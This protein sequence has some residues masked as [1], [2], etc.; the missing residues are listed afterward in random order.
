[1]SSEAQPTHLADNHAGAVAGRGGLPHTG[2]V[3][4]CDGYWQ[5]ECKKEEARYLTRHVRGKP[6]RFPRCRKRHEDEVWNL[7]G[8]GSEPGGY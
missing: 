8:P 4:P 2:D 6:Q 5:P 3:V 1:M 7:R